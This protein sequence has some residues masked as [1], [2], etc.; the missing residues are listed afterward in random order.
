MA[1]MTVRTWPIADPGALVDLI[2]ADQNPMTWIQHGDGIVGWGET[3]RVRVKGSN[4]FRT[5]DEWWQLFVESLDIRDY[6]GTFGT[7]PIAFASF[8]FAADQSWSTL[9]VPRVVIG[10]RGDV[11]WMTAFGDSTVPVELP[12]VSPIQTS[13]TVSYAD[14]EFGAVDYRAAVAETVRRIREG[15]LAKAV[16]A[17]DLLVINDAPIDP[18]FVLD[19]LARRFADCWTFSV[20][21]WVGATPELLA[22]RRGRSVESRILAGSRSRTEK[23]SPVAALMASEKDRHEHA[24]SVDNL[25][26][27]LVQLC[28]ELVVPDE[29]SVVQLHNIAHLATDL[30]GL[31]HAAAPARLLQIAEAIH[32]TTAVCGTPPSAAIA[33]INELERMDRGRYSGP[34]GWVDAR[35]DGE[36]GLALR[37]AQLD[38]PVARLFAG[39][40]IVAGSEPDAE[41]REASVK[42][43]AMLQTLDGQELIAGGTAE[44]FSSWRR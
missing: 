2:P 14:G 26:A 33:L 21:G 1:T 9:V 40:G 16:L 25:A 19:R 20:D 10:R 30:E 11:A 37:C 3:A 24:L 4:R 41:V 18:R 5:A 42:L 34:V 7:G 8:A 38:G 28:S 31:L 43:E 13:A 22:R 39:C 32:P 36:L 44:L 12:T 15:H 29:P 35:G 23:G 27:D 17:H 6:V